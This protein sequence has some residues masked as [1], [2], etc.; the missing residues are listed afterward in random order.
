MAER[1]SGLETEYAFTALGHNGNGLNRNEH[2]RRFFG[3]AQARLGHIKG[4]GGCDMFL[5]NAGRL[6]MDAG[7]HP[8]FCTPECANPWDIV[9]Y[10]LAGERML[11]DVA[12]QLARDSGIAEAAL[13]KCNVDYG[14]TDSTWGCHESYL[15]RTDP[16]QLSG[17]IIPHLVSRLIYTGAGG[18]S[19]SA[20]GMSF[21]LSPRVAHLQHEVSNSSMHDRGIFHTKDESLSTAGYHRLHLLCGESLCS[22]QSSWLKVGTTALVVAMVEGGLCPG[23][24]V[25]LNAPL[26]AMQRFAA[27]PQCKTTVLAADKH[28]HLSALTIQRHYLE[29]AEHNLGRSFMPPWAPQVCER[30][31]EM[32]D[33]LADAPQSVSTCLDWAI[34]LALFRQWSQQHGLAWESLGHWSCVYQRL[35][36][37]LSQ[38]PNKNVENQIEFILGP[39]SPIRSEVERLNVYLELRGLEWSG[40]RSY[41]QLRSTLFEIDT[42][43]GQLGPRGIFNSL[44]RQGVLD[45][46]VSGV[47]NI[48]HAMGNPPA[49]GRGKLRGQWISRL[50]G[51]KDRFNCCWTMILDKQK[52]RVLDM[53]DPF[54]EQV[55][56]QDRPADLPP[57]PPPPPG[58]TRRG[59][60]TDIFEAVR[61]RLAASGPRSQYRRGQ[62]VVIARL[63]E[64]APSELE[65]STAMIMRVEQDE[66]GTIYR[67]NIDQ[68]R[69]AWR[70]CHLLTA[71]NL[72]TSSA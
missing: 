8:E 31:R 15:H 4:M 44:D 14:G 69:H 59:R 38:T 54:A 72:F 63:I 24:A 35:V 53:S 27:D 2:L 29:M 7:L 18:F 60:A 17:Q 51:E 33:R 28:H 37:A 50:A 39:Q 56:W 19:V 34:K 71:D 48:E 47:D 3:L 1:L 40:L 11:D 10:T 66:R 46:A 25:Q 5:I 70:T 55:D 32:L 21:S 49:I 26:L 9:R 64:D 45:H 6:Y 23:D 58:A 68:G 22:H 20:G 12:Q 65:G 30:W 16:R 57:P 41:L 42:R 13:F 67:L 62:R 36:S 52:W 61:Q 43:F